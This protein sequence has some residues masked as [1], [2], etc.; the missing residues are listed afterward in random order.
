MNESNVTE[1]L[2]AKLCVI[3][4]L[5]QKGFS[6]T[7][8]KDVTVELEH[9]VLL[10]VY[11]DDD[12][13]SFTFNF[14]TKESDAVFISVS[15][16]DINKVEGNT[17]TKFNISTY[18]DYSY[19]SDIGGD[20]SLNL[21][22]GKI[23]QSHY[24]RSKAIQIVRAFKSIEDKLVETANKAV[25][26]RNKEENDRNEANKLKIANRVAEYEKNNRKR[27]VQEAVEIMAEMEKEA[28]SGKDVTREFKFITLSMGKEV[29]KTLSII[30]EKG[31]MS[32]KRNMISLMTQEDVQDLITKSWVKV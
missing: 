7:E 18:D 1:A 29:T 24:A 11:S 21:F 4:E 3:E 8:P 6:L 2:K 13:D 10:R 31:R 28:E 25:T 23:K 16:R 19:F 30:W 22:E 12:L 27:A 32:W 14:S 26:A 5:T 17:V 15:I 20:E 9:D